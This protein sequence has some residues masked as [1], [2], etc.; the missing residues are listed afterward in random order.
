MQS[1]NAMANPAEMQEEA[2]T[3][4]VEDSIR[5]WVRAADERYRQIVPMKFGNFVLAAHE[6]DAYCAEFHQEKSFRGDNARALVRMVAVMARIQAESQE[7]QQRQ[8]ST[9]LWRPHADALAILQ[10]AAARVIENALS[11]VQV[12]T[13]RGL[14]EKAKL[15]TATIDRL[16]NRIEQVHETLALAGVHVDAP[17]TI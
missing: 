5:G 9:H 7:L 12:A 10:Q 4:S 11:T 17:R 8:N 13:Q 16:R 14:M 2:R 6:A 3:R 1:L 15:L